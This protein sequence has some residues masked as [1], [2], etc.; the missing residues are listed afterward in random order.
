MQINF[1]DY[2]LSEF[3]VKDVIFCGIDAV[4][5]NPNHIGTKF[6][7]K[8]K[9]FRSSIWSK[10]TGILLSAGLKKFVNFSEN[11]EN[12]PVPTSL[13]GCKIVDKIDGSCVIID[14][15][16]RNL[17]MRTRGTST[18]ATMENAKDF[19]YCLS[20]YPA[21]AIWLASNSNYSLLFELT[22]PN[23]KI[24]LDYGN[25][26]DFWLIGAINKNDYSLMTQ[27]KLDELSKEIGV[28]RPEYYTFSSMDSLLDSIRAI[29][30]K[31]G[32]CLYSKNDSEIHKIKGETYLKLHRF[33]SNATFENTVD[34][35]VEFGMPSYQEFEAKLIQTFDFECYQ[36]VRGFISTICDGWKEVKKIEDGMKKFVDSIKNLP[37]RKDKALRIIESYGGESNNRAGMIFTILDNKPFTND[38]Y[39]KLLYQVTKN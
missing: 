18:Y 6:T 10:D 12:F 23:L 5:I 19:D 7:Q 32:C 3:I 29:E 27:D 8:N 21:I 34:L 35:F 24:V 16:N 22:T 9:I 33:K 26:P 20:K 28:K 36:M 13:N 11:P 37:T 4:L 30:G 17:S 15:I 14:L 31:E 38:M 39:K 1:Q 2:D 25:E